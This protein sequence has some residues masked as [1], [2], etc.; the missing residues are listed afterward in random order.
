MKFFEKEAQFPNKV[1]LTKV[2]ANNVPLSDEPIFANIAKDGGEVFVEGTHI[3]AE[4]LNNVNWRDDNSISFKVSAQNDPEPISKED[5]VQIYTKPDGTTMLLPAGEGK[6]P[7]ILGKVVGTLVNVNGVDKESWDADT[8]QDKLTEQQ[9][10]NI[11][12]V[13]NKAETSD[14]SAH[15][16]NSQIHVTQADKD[17]LNTSANDLTAHINN[18]QIH[19]TNQLNVLNNVFNLVYPVGAIYMS[20]NSKS[21]AELFGG[22]WAAWGAGRVPVCIGNNNET[23]YTTSEATGGSEKAT[24]EHSHSMTVYNSKAFW[25]GTARRSVNLTQPDKDNIGDMETTNNA[26]YKILRDTN[27]LNGGLPR[28]YTVER[29]GDGVFS[30][31]DSSYRVTNSGSSNFADNYS[32]NGEHRH[33]EPPHGHTGTVANSG[34]AKGNMP[35]YITCYMWKRTA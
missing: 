23:N 8:K 4:I 35:P 30:R 28:M 16:N 1:K 29:G 9:I 31:I 7:V 6:Q 32:Y 22:T 18:S 24:A 12:A 25:S 26:Q 11:A 33:V 13:L 20:V 34:T 15:T 21:P 14:L 27:D 5:E 19:F 17:K 2:D 3:T 10:N